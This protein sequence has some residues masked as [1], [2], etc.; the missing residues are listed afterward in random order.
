MAAGKLTYRDAGVDMD[1]ADRLVSRI[2]KLAASTKTAD[3]LSGVGLFAAAVQL[4]RGY[5]DPVLMTA[6]DGVGTKLALARLTGRHDT[7]GIDLVAMNVNDVLTSGARPLCFLDYLSMGRLAS[8]DATAMIPLK[9]ADVSIT[10]EV[11]TH[12][13]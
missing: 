6:T 1:A 11:A 9:D 8:I 7:I 4:P 2:G 12:Q 5:R 3:V 10:D 13:I